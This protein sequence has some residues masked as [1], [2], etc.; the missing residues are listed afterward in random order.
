[1]LSKLTK[2]I[3]FSAVSLVLI[4][5]LAN[6]QPATYPDIALNVNFPPPVVDRIKL[7]DL[8]KFDPAASGG[9]SRILFS[10]EIRNTN[11]SAPVSIKANAV[12]LAFKFNGN[13]ITSFTNG[14]DVIL[15]AGEVVSLNNLNALKADS[16]FSFKIKGGSF[17]A[18][19]IVRSLYG[20]DASF[21]SI[22]PG[23]PLPAGEYTFVLT[24]AGA[25]NNGASSSIQLSNPTGYVELIG[26]GST[27]GSGDP[28]VI[29]DRQPVITWIGDAPGF[30]LKVVEKG[31]NDKTV[32]DL[33][34]K[35][36]NFETTTKSRFVRYPSAGVTPLMPG[37][38]YVILLASQV[39]TMGSKKPEEQFAT[40][41]EFKVQASQSAG[42]SASSQF[43]EN[44]K[45]LVGE[46]YAGEF[47]KLQGGKVVGD[48]TLDGQRMSTR[49]FMELGQKIQIGQATVKS[50][51]V[52]P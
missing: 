52:K 23:A 13:G 48:P 11:T 5:G 50:V 39:N 33:L 49:D 28:M 32:G 44:L 4:G 45:A 24:L 17:D 21:S 25:Q 41:L 10:I 31:P 9:S 19:A 7:S 40:P 18:N 12:E 22:D 15:R 29:M 37:K 3:G 42:E 51:R 6:A 46:Q 36:A 34:S 8:A 26:P 30:L 1:M 20:D 14:R 27:F 16:R 47:D 38:T 35:T 2:L 43:L